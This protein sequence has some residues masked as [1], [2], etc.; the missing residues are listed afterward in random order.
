MKKLFLTFSII[1]FL[2]QLTKFLVRT[3]M[4]LYD[5]IPVIKGFFNITYIL[6]PG[7]AFGLF[8][9]VNH[10]ISRVFFIIISLIASAVVFYLLITEI[11]F[12]FRSYAYTLIIAG[13]IGNLV[14]RLIVGQVVDF[15]DFNIGRYHYPAFNVADSAVT[16]G[17]TILAIDLIFFNKEVS[18][19]NKT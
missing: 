2:D 18:N 7:V 9:H 19:E 17:L 13:A 8:S 10:D 15:L 5:S 3:G 1:L 6:N 16:I 14:D 11:N 4:N 12:K